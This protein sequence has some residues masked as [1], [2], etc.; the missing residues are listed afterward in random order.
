MY[1]ISIPRS[2]AY[3]SILISFSLSSM[4]NISNQSNCLF[5]PKNSTL[6][7]SDPAF[8]SYVFCIGVFCAPILIIFLDTMIV[9]RCC[10]KFLS[11][12]ICSYWIKVALVNMISASGVG[13]VVVVEA[14]TFLD[15]NNFAEFVSKKS[16][17]L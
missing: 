11:N 3:S 2:L 6:I 15:S 13:A 14:S 4:V 7:E 1:I 9:S 8:I 10:L 12:K 16:F 5:A 17:I